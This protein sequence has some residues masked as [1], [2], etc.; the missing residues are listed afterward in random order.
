[1]SEVKIF[2]QIAQSSLQKVHCGEA[3]QDFID[4]KRLVATGG[5]CHGGRQ[6]MGPATSQRALLGQEETSDTLNIPMG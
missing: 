6:M 5:I 3:E 4:E 1:M 2:L